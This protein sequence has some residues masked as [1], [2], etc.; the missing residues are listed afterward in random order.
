METNEAKVQN[1][2]ALPLIMTAKQ[3]ATV[4]QLH[5]YF[6]KQMCRDGKLSARKIGRAWRI[7]REA[8]KAM[9]EGERQKDE[10]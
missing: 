10:G 3:A 2:D 5:P 1:W 8:V 6:V 4:L 7:S 9:M